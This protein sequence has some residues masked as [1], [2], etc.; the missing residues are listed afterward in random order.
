MELLVTLK[1]SQKQINT[2]NSQM[3]LLIDF[4]TK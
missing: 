4:T 3:V 2:A 1:E